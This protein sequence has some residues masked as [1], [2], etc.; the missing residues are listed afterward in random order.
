MLDLQ[1]KLS[2]YV[3]S[4]TSPEDEILYN[5][6]RTTHIHAMQ[7][8]MLSGHLQGKLLE[9]FSHMISPQ[10]IL[11]IGTYTGYSAI[12]LAKGLQNNGT[13]HT[14]DI[15]AELRH[16]AEEYINKTDYKNNIKLHTGN[17]LEIISQ[18]NCT[19][20]LVYI[21]G[22]K[23]EYVA[24]YEEVIDRTNLGGI[25]IADN[26]L[27]SGKILEDAKPNDK[28][29]A[30]LIKF[31]NLIQNDNRVENILL[32]LRDGMMIMRKIR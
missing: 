17:A 4:H 30:E 22:D 28:Y 19:F 26:V 31:N 29:T 8:R 24:Y 9:F 20:D 12:C 21:D 23:R 2:D 3:L 1:K 25:I 13:L 5:L 18:L 15:N 10:N 7:P 27:W 16:I 32:P 6:T 14:I 11:E